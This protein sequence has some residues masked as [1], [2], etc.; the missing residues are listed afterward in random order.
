MDERAAEIFSRCA[1]ELETALA[2]QKREVGEPV[3]GVVIIDGRPHLVRDPEY[4]V[5]TKRAQRL[6]AA[7]KQQDDERDAEMFKR[8]WDAA[9]EHFTPKQQAVRK[10]RRRTW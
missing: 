7:P 10:W 6:Y 9:K 4:F 1:N 5:R 8:G 3:D 2:Q